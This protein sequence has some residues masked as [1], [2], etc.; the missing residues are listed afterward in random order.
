MKTLFR[1]SLWFALALGSLH[2]AD[3]QLIAAVRAAP[4]LSEV[5]RSMKRRC[6]SLSAD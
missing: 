5:D 3:D 2:A 4:A 1:L 6:R